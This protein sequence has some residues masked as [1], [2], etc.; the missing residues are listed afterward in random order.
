MLTGKD[1]ILCISKGVIVKKVKSN[2]LI[3]EG[4]GFVFVAAPESVSN[5]IIPR[6]SMV[7]LIFMLIVLLEILAMS[8][9]DIF[10]E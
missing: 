9:L 8:I 3:V 1:N 10:N 5:R 6:L 2:S 7:G 4:P